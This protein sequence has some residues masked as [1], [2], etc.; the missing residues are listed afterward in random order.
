[1]TPEREIR[2]VLLDGS[3]VIM[4]TGD[5]VLYQASRP[6][7]IPLSIDADGIIDDVLAALEESQQTIANAKLIFETADAETDFDDV[8]HGMYEALG[9]NKEGSDKS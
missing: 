3:E 7:A 5:R 9:G 8:I 2:V 4:N 6:G 1:M